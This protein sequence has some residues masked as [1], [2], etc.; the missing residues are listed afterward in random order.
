MKVC[1]GCGTAFADAAWTCPTCGFAP[2]MG[3]VLEFTT[4]ASDSYHADLFALLEHVEP[5]NFWFRSRND[6][7]CWLVDRYFASAQTLLEV[8]CGTGFV[9]QGLREHRPGLSLT[10]V[11]LFTEGL[12]VARRRLP[13]VTL[14]RADA[15][16][17]PFEDE[18]DIVCAFDVLEHLDDDVAALRQLARSVR[19]GGG[20]IVSVPQHQF[21][22]S[23]SDD[24]AAHRRRY[25]RAQL[26]RNVTSAGFEVVRATS[27][28]ML[29]FP[30]MIAA[31]VRHRTRDAYD[32]ADEFKLSPPANWLLGQVMAVERGLIQAGLSLPFG[33]S[34]FVVGRLPE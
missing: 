12:A 2:R 30:A 15:Y 29:L 1:I 6:L 13:E 34:L 22:W 3:D 33:G 17:L 7:I 18:Y 26:I 4:Q 10:G 5:S 23:A 28:V 16:E 14:L 21:L 25:S 20:L 19:P 27:F 9:L 24:A 32:F 11:E 31:R 8:G